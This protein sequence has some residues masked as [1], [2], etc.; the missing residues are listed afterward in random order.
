MNFFLFVKY[1]NYYQITKIYLFK[2][3]KEKSNNPLASLC[4]GALALKYG[5]VNTETPSPREVKGLININS[6]IISSFY[7]YFDLDFLLF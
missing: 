6:I 7:F 1:N 3:I 2:N 4:A 5:D